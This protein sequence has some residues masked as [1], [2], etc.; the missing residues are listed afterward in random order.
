MNHYCCVPQ[1]SSWIKRNPELSFHSFLKAGMEK[2]LVETKLGTNELGDRR[3]MWI[4]LLKLISFK[5]RKAVPS[6]NLPKVSHDVG[7]GT[8]RSRPASNTSVVTETLALCENDG[9]ED[10]ED[11]QAAEGLLALIN[12]HKP[13]TVSLA[14]PSNRD[15]GVQVNT[16]KV[17]T[18]C[19]LIDSD[20]KLRNFTGLH[21][22]AIL[23]AI[24]GRFE[25]H[26]S[27]KRVQRI[28]VRQRIVLLFTKFKTSLTYVTLGSLF[29]ITPNLA[30]TYIY[31]AS[32]KVIFE[33][34]NLISLLDANRDAIMVDKGFLIDDICNL[35][36]IKLI[37]PPFLQSKTQLTRDESILNAK[38][39]SARI[40]IERSNQRLKIF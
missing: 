10:L 5:K 39:A 21:N 26:H 22:S 40:H 30:K 29:G 11:R 23:D 13:T 8:V 14:G 25:E 24:V 27:D 37:R 12:S 3:Q 36:K 16:P 15:I 9:R 1:C 19:E 34:C 18:L 35:Y 7:A 17:L 4:R 33:D 32:D 6:R 28:N 20:E 2:V 38:I 31:E